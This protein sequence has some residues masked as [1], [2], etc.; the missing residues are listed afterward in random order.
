MYGALYLSL[1]R[2]LSE[3]DCVIRSNSAAEL[4]SVFVDPKKPRFF[5]KL[6]LKDSVPHVEILPLRDEVPPSALLQQ[7][8]YPIAVESGEG[9][10]CSLHRYPTWSTFLRGYCS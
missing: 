10:E 6:L 5:F 1:I 4:Y 3:E 2:D 9:V 8:L 7:N